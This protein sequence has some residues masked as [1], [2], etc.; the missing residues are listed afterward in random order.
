MYVN[1][2]EQTG[3]VDINMNIAD[4]FMIFCIQIVGCCSIRMN[5]NDKF[6]LIK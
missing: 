3:T 2:Y 5:R 4:R 1:K 6:R